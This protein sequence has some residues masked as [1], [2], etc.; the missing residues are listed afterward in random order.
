MIIIKVKGKRID[1]V[2]KEYRQ[3]V[4]KLRLLKELR[5]RR[6]FKKKSTKKREQ[7]NKAKYK[8]KHGKK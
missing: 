5:N 7:L 8:N 2:L 3:K 1:Y 6:E 4:D